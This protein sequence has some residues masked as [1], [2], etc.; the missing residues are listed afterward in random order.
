MSWRNVELAE[1]MYESEFTCRTVPTEFT[2]K[3]R[4]SP[5]QTAT[6]LLAL[7][8]GL[9]TTLPY[10][11]A[12]DQPEE[13]PSAV[14]AVMRL[15]KS[16]RVPEQR[17][18]AI[19]ELVCE[20]GNEHDLEYA[21]RSAV[22]AEM[23][24]DEVRNQV[25][26]GLVD[27]GRNR[28]VF[29]ATGHDELLPLLDHKDEAWRLPAIELAAIWKV[30]D[31]S[32]SLS[33]I[34]KSQQ[35]GRRERRLV[36]RSLVTVDRETAGTVIDELLSNENPF[37]VRVEG[38][39]SLAQL[40]VDAA[41]ASTA[42]LL[43]A[44]TEDDELAD[45]VQVFLNRKNGPEKLAAAIDEHQP[46]ADTAKRMLRQMFSVGRSDPSLANVLSEIAGIGED[47]PLPTPEELQQLIVE[48]SAD[49]DPVRGE[50]VFRRADLSCMKCHAVSKGGGDIGPDLSA[51]GASSPVD[52]ILRSIL[53]PDEAIKEAFITKTVL[54]SDGEI[55]QGI[56]VERTDD[57]LVLRESTGRQ[58]E[59]PTDDIDDEAEGKSLMPK[60]LVKFMTRAELI[61]LAAFLSQLGRPDGDYPIRSTQRMQR[62]RVLR[63]VA[64]VV[65]D[66]EVEVS[67]FEDLVLAAESWIPAYAMTAGDLPLDEIRKQARI[68]SPVLFVQGEFVVLDPG[69]IDVSVNAPA[70]TIVWVGSNEHRSEDRAIDLPPGR[71]PITLRVPVSEESA[72][73]VR[74]EL[75]RPE[76]SA[77]EFHVVDGV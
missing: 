25:L 6:T 32:E 76:G 64:D 58:R 54:T 2:R 12:D 65:A 61:D 28:K 57:L 42:E 48:V 33:R 35:T 37:A 15:L 40:D 73:T 36:L 11:R 62:F 27:A 16:G 17:L 26:L 69:K 20:R 23:W 4:F 19:L 3:R 21:W 60:G 45:L 24:S 14:G 41:A 44:A 38:I 56:V 29:P 13:A 46:T 74:I 71:Y 34:A 72:G 8:L 70:G 43:L 75:S 77:A 67:L 22:D 10:S 50:E 51:L 63:E 66:G 18:S 68:D 59:I 7:V 30:V 53:N 5:K 52:Y 1:Q 31:A 9:L 39:I 47:P 55:L 49:G